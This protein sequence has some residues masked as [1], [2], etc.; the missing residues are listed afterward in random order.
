MFLFE[1]A[2]IKLDDE[3]VEESIIINNDDDNIIT[4]NNLDN[5]K[6]PDNTITSKK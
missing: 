3:E 1:I 5:S 6:D 4:T 2:K